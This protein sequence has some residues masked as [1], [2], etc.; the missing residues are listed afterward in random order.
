[1][2]EVFLKALRY[3]WD[4]TEKGDGYM[5]EI[6]LGLGLYRHMLTD[7][8]FAFAR[9]CGCT[10]L[11][12]HL[13]DYYSNQIVTATNDKVNYGEA[14]ALEGIWEEDSMIALQEKAGQ[15]G[16]TIYGIENFSG[17]MSCWMARKGRVRWNI[18]RKSYAMRGRQEFI[19]LDIIS[20]W[21]AYGGTR[22][23]AH[24][25]AGRM[26]HVSTHPGLRWIHQFQKAKSGI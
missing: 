6:K 5:A 1:M 22:K 16:L 15:H 3:T 10:H 13:A 20:V 25:A 4:I 7:E 23:N 17:M 24:A 8:Y 12:V 21:Q 18:L 9:Q 26:G 19:P 2:Q 14:K 11:I